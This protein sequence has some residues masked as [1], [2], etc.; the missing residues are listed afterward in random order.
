[1]YPTLYNPFTLNDG[2]LHLNGQD[3]SQ[4]RAFAISE[5]LDETEIVRI[6]NYIYS[7]GRQDESLV[8]NISIEQYPKPIW[9]N[10]HITD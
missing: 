10:I 2:K 7:L 9:N 3:V 5:P 6:F 4:I 8:R 1:M